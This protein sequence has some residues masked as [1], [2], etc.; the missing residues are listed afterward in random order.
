MYHDTLPPFEAA[1][2]RI[3]APLHPTADVRGPVVLDEARGL[4]FYCNT[5]ASPREGISLVWWANN[6]WNHQNT[7]NAASNPYGLRPA[8]NLLLDPVA[9]KLFYRTHNR[10]IAACYFDAA[11]GWHHVVLA[12]SARPALGNLSLA[13]NGHIFYLGDDNAVHALRY[14]P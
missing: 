5:D 6:R 8:D 13:P 12:S 10:E 14:L 4:F 1:P 2:P 3:T 9:G 11:S 7:N